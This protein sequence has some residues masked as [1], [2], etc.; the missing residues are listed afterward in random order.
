MK[1][2]V[3]DAAVFLGADEAQ[4]SDWIEEEELPAQR[5]RGHY[6]IN[7]ADLLEWATARGIAVAPRAFRLDRGTPSLAEALRAGGVHRD[8]GGE[9]LAGVIRNIV[10]LLPLA[11]GADREMLLHILLARESLGVTPVGDGIAIPHVRTPIILS[12]AGAVIALSF[13]TAP[14]ELRAP[15]GLPVDIFFLLVCPT[16]HVHLAMLAKLAYGLKDAAFRAAV[17]ERA[18]TEEIVALAAALEG[19]F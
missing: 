8:V 11:D 4:V 15:D 3:P 6:R 5:I 2:S 12:P 9:D 7:R 17:R 1:L 10:A 16:V 18:S 14:L 13:L 19:A